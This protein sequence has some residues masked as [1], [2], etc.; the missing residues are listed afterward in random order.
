MGRS[1]PRARRNPA[2][3]KG[4]FGRIMNHYQLFWASYVSDGLLE[5]CKWW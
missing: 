3:L 2:R 5:E 1:R 4:V